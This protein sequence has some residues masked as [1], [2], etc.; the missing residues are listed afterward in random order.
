M[1]ASNPGD[2]P[3]SNRDVIR[4]RQLWLLALFLFVK[5][6]SQVAFQGLWGVPYI[7]SVYDVSPTAAAGA[8][9]MVAAGYVVAAPIIG[10]LADV[11]AARGMN[12]IAAQR[13]L[14]VATTMLYVV[15]WV[16]IVLAPGFLPLSAMY[17]LLFV[18]GTSVSSASLVFGIAKELFPSNV[19]GLAIG[20]VN[21][22]SILGGAAMPPVVG[23][24]I[25]RLTAAGVQGG[26]V[27]SRAMIPC[28]L[29]AAVGLALISMVG[30]PS[31]RRVRPGYPA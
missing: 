19:S 29:A 23:W 3:G 18:M 20:L 12:L 27:Y 26:A 21:I 9:T 8:V 16:P 1:P 10:R 31:G 11:M 2:E 25:D 17:L 15:T 24:F 5:Y 14:L 13:R 30:R 22:T 6:G 28:L 4:S 7:A